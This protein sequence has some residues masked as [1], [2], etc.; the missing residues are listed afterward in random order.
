MK[1]S[2]PSAY[3]VWSW[4]CPVGVAPGDQGHGAAD[5]LPRRVQRRRHPQ[6]R[7]G[8]AHLLPVPLVLALYAR[9]LL[10]HAHVL[11]APGLHARQVAHLV[12]TRYFFP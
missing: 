7:G 2:Q 12:S 11:R 8:A 3:D 6:R 5:A 9:R 1:K 10:P 4:W